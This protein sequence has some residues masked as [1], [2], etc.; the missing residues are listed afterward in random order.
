MTR[1]SDPGDGGSEPRYRDGELIVCFRAGVGDVERAAERSLPTDATVLQTNENLHAALVS[2]PERDVVTTASSLE[3]RAEVRFAERNEIVTAD[4]DPSSAVSTPTDTA[5]FVPDDPSFDDQYGPEQV[6][7]PGAWEETLGSDAVTI[8][9]LDSGVFYDHEDLAANMSTVVPNHGVDFA[10]DNADGEDDSDPAPKDV[11]EE[12]HGTQVAGILGASTDNGTGVAGISN[13]TILAV[14]VLGVDG[15]GSTWDIGTGIE[16]AATNGADVINLSLGSKGEDPFYW[17]AIETADENGVLTVGSAGNDGEELEEYGPAS[18]CH[19]AVSAVESGDENTLASF[20]N[21][22]EYVDLAAPGTSYWNTETTYPADDDGNP[23]PTAYDGFSGTSMAAP[24]VSGT[25][26][27]VLSANDS[28]SVDEL[29]EVLTETATDVGLPAVEQ[30]AG[31]VNAGGAVDAVTDQTGL[32]VALAGETGSVTV[33]HGVTVPYTATAQFDE[34]GFD[35]TDEVTVTVGDESILSVDEAAA[36][37]T[38]E[39]GGETTLTATEDGFEAT[40]DVT[41]DLV[42]EDLSFAVGGETETLALVEGATVEYGATAEYSDGSTADVTDDIEL[43]VEGNETPVLT[44]DETAAE[45]TAQVTGETTVTATYEGVEAVVGV[46]VVEPLDASF[47]VTPTD[48]LVGEAVTFDAAS[49]VGTVESYEWAFTA[50]SSADTSLTTG[51]STGGQSGQAV[52]GD[53]FENGT[54]VKLTRVFE[55][56]EPVEV[57]LTV[58][59]ITGAVEMVEDTI[60]VSEPGPVTVSATTESPSVGDTAATLSIEA[61]NADSITVRKLWTDWETGLDDPADGPTV[62][63]RVQETGAF[64]LAW[65]TLQRDVSTA[66]TVDIPLETYVGGEYLLAVVANRDLAFAASSVLLEIE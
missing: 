3:Q 61:T 24:I 63:D 12:T 38:A 16:W 42:V 50:G 27:L 57:S 21:S 46:T 1:P 2:L 59:D 66:V 17:I 48:P 62:T 49:T 28:L 29:V 23:D 10:S 55:E 33:D 37:V 6:D 34:F 18:Q 39:S 7:A 20:S 11:E 54:G 4:A 5:G 30:G 52:A 13:C 8:A 14:R 36:T 22:G 26:G 64:D 44:I 58:T 60:Q 35:V 40:V 43:A 41:V 15:T 65:E 9:V 31:Q 47:V 53:T 32:A 51:A 56:A 19:I 25:A 45:L